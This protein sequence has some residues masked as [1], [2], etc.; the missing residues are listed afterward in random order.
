V[1]R[2]ANVELEHRIS[3]GIL[4][5]PDG[6][7]RIVVNVEGV[8]Y[9]YRLDGATLHPGPPP[10]KVGGRLVEQQVNRAK[11]VIQPRRA[12]P[13]PITVTDCYIVTMFPEP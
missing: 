8:G 5:D 7:Y 9:H 10:S 11:V 13:P 2:V 6:R 4:P 1:A 12:P 3:T